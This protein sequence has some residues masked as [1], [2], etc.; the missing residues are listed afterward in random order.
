MTIN[1]LLITG[2]M[3]FVGWNLTQYFE[4]LGIRVISVS[5]QQQGYYEQFGI[6]R[7]I[8]HI[9]I[10]DAKALE[11]CCKRHKPD[12]IL[13]AAALSQ[14]ARCEEQP[15]KA[16]AINV[17]GTHNALRCAQMLDIPF[18]FTSTDLVF[19][20]S[21][22]FYSEHDAT[23]PFIEYGKTKVAA[24][25]CIRAVSEEYNFTKWIITRPALVYGN[26][27]AWTNVFPQFAVRL[28]QDG[29]E[30]MLFSDQYRTPVYVFDIARAVRLLLEQ[31][32][33]GEI[34]HLGGTERLHRVE[35]VER[36]CAQAGIST[37]GIRSV[38]MDDIPQY[39]TK[40]RDVSLNSSFLTERTTWQPTPLEQAFDDMLRS[41]DYL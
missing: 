31:Q 22:G 23:T 4:Q 8:E 28:L 35:F 24:E 19:D 41:Q 38:Q 25:H 39:T 15:H 34:F 6:Q 11:T 20:G 40:V 5:S 16:H 12:A 10:C 14:P 33:F 9:N 7:T 37:N 13:H 21:Q 18:V 17:L 36:F 32:C 1:T 27:F 30:A 3:G 2:G 26:G 29:K